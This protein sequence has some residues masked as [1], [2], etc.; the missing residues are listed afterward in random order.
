MNTPTTVSERP[1]QNPLM[2]LQSRLDALA[3]D[4]RQL[5]Q[6]D[7]R[8]LRMKVLVVSRQLLEQDPLDKASWEHQMAELRATYN[9]MRRQLALL[10]DDEISYFAG[11]L[12]ALRSNLRRSRRAGQARFA[13]E[14]VLQEGDVPAFEQHPQINPNGVGTVL[15]RIQKIRADII[16]ILKIYGDLK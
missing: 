13:A 1:A 14:L 10:P 12:N 16:R 7:K 3:R 4:A 9:D 6:S 11:Q 2:E 15:G 5:S 8:E